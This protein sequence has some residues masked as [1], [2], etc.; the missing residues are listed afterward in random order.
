VL[1]TNKEDED[2]LTDLPDDGEAEEA[3]TEQRALFAS[4]EMQHHDAVARQFMITERRAVAE[5]VAK[6][7][8][9]ACAAAH[10]RNIEAA[11]RDGN[12]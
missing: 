2:D 11:A 10:R 4:F 3:A 12:D 9:A 5:K 7:Q 6:A 1:Q 8:A